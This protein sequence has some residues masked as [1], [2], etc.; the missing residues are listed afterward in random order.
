MS[1]ILTKSVIHEKYT[2]LKNITKNKGGLLNTITR[3]DFEKE[4]EE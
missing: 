1:L 2:I 3:Y 4:F